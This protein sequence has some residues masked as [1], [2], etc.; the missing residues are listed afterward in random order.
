MN[1]SLATPGL[2]TTGLSRQSIPSLSS[3]SQE[4]DTLADK[5]TDVG[6][7]EE[8]KQEADTEDRTGGGSSGGA[9]PPNLRFGSLEFAICCSVHS[10]LQFE[11]YI[12]NNHMS[13]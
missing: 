8:D 11:I 2:G 9:L 5:V 10:R 13:T 12:H 1:P 7:I 3:R 6:Q 4:A